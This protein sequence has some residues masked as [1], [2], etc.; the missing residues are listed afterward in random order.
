MTGG[1]LDIPSVF[2]AAL[3]ISG[4]YQIARGNMAAP[5]WYTAF[6]YAFG[7]FSRDMLHKVDEP[8]SIEQVS[9]AEEY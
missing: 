5:A 9:Q 8:R 6:W 1:E 7:I 2:F 3:L 4:I